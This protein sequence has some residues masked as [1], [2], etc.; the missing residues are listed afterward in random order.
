ME[1]SRTYEKGFDNDLYYHA[2]ETFG[3]TNQTI[4][5][6][7]ELSELQK[8]LTKTLRGS[9][10]FEH[11]IE[12]IADVEIM[13]DQLKIMFNINSLDLMRA[14]LKK[15][16]RLKERI[17]KKIETITRTVMEA[18]ENRQIRDD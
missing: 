14:K 5:A 6:I 16:N 17:E 18:H 7:E 12:E 11:V 13:L 3:K 15:Q 10:N 9:F 1:D 8:E 4:V 2:I